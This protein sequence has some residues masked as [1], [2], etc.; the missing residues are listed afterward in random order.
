MDI[1]PVCAN[2]FRFRAG[3]FSLTCLDAGCIRDYWLEDH[4][5]KGHCPKGQC[6]ERREFSDMTVLF[7]QIARV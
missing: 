6:P 1:L 3:R 2:L 4:C 5:P 7:R